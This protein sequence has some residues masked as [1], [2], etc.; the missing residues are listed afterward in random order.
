M[1]DI[2]PTHVYVVIGG[3]LH[4]PLRAFTTEEKAKD[5]IPRFCS[6]WEIHKISLI[7]K[8]V[9]P[10]SCTCKEQEKHLCGGNLSSCGC[11]F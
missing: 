4:V 7:H 11:N 8:C 5:Y 1:N 10:C 9:C 6:D 2:I 3:A